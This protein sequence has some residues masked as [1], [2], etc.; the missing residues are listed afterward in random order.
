MNNP[1]LDNFF[2]TLEEIGRSL[3]RAGRYA[4]GAIAAM[5]WPLLMLTCVGLALAI[6]IVPMALTLFIAFVIIKLAMAALANRKRG[7][8]T[9]HKSVDRDGE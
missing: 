3:V 8:I 7:A 2:T 5:S 1:A 6:V 4:A 9:A